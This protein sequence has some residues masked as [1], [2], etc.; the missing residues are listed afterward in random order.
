MEY[1]KNYPCTRKSICFIGG[2]ETEIA[3]YLRENG[4]EEDICMDE[5]PVVCKGYY[6]VDGNYKK[7]ATAQD[8]TDTAKTLFGGNWN[9]APSVGISGK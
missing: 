8:I 1:G 3:E 9:G 2:A 7:R 5:L 6:S 4:L